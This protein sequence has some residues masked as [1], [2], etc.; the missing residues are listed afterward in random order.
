MAKPVDK[1]GGVPLHYAALGGDT[2]QVAAL[3]AAGAD[4]DAADLQGFRP[5]HLACQQG[6]LDAA[7]ALLDAGADVDAV[8]TCG[9]TP[10]FV[11]VFNSRGRGDL[12]ALLRS[13]GA[14]PS[15]LNNSDQSPVGLARLIGN[16]DVAWFFADLT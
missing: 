5:L 3:L 13:R 2:A 14:D 12:I 1:A 6:S 11:A 4:P 16:F 9:N 10:L 15:H 8:N 7:Q